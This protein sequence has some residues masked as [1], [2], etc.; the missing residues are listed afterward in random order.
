MRTAFINKLTELARKDPKIFLIV[1]DLGF[2][3]VEKFAQEFPERFLNIGVAE[4]NMTGVAAGL[5]L[6]GFHPFTYSIGNF[7]TLRCFEQIRNDLCYHKLPVTVVSVGGGFSYGPLGASHHATEDIGALRTLPNLTICA[8]GD[9]SETGICTEILSTLP[10]PSYLRLGKAG[11]KQVHEQGINF[12]LGEALFIGSGDSE[13]I[14]TTG[15]ILAFAKEESI[16]LKLNA[17]LV[18]FPFIKPID[19]SALL[20]MKNAKKI[21]T[22]EEHQIN[23]GLGSAI[24]EGFNDLR[25]EGKLSAIPMIRRV[26]I[27]DKFSSQ[28]GSQKHLRDT[29]GLNLTDKF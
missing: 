7:T 12:N 13:F 19:K 1:G 2:S 28:A 11:E 3:V 26:A 8:P 5:A 23:C 24:L 20:K 16:R 9:P 10:S 22:L 21:I 15:N 25:E 4:Q 17:T 27:K 6:S 29:T 18:S 14:C